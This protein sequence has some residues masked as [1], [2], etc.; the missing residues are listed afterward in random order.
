MCPIN[1]SLSKSCS[2]SCYV[3]Q[4]S[5]LGPLLFLLY[6]NDLPNCLSNCEPRI[7]ADDNNL[8]YAG[9]NA[10]NVQLHLNQDLENAHN[11]LIASKLTLNMTKTE[12]MCVPWDDQPSVLRNAPLSD[13]VTLPFFFSKYMISE[14]HLVS[15]TFG[16]L[17]LT[18]LAV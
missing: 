6:I 17:L 1:A 18:F 2:L 11:L 13:R 7:Y 5:I 10:D 8:T 9:D 4:G 3:P 15:K 14:N 12:L 16:F